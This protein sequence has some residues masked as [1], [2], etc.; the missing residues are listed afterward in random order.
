MVLTLLTLIAAVLDTI[1]ATVVW[2]RFRGMRAAWYFVATILVRTVFAFS[3]HVYLPA[4]TSTAEVA[5]VACLRWVLLPLASLFQLLFFLSAYEERWLTRPRVRAIAAAFALFGALLTADVAARVAP[6]FEAPGP[7]AGIDPFALGPRP[8]LLVLFQLGWL[9]GIAVLA[10]AMIRTP[11]ER[12]PLLFVLVASLAGV[13]LGAIAG[14]VGE[15]GDAAVLFDV[16][17]TG[18]FAYLLFRRHVFETT[19]IAIDGALASMAEGIAVLADDGAVLFANPS[20][21]ALLRLRA[22]MT[23][24]I[25]AMRDPPVGEML[26]ALGAQRDLFQVEREEH[27]VLLTASPI[28]DQDGHLRGHLLLAQ[29]VTEQEQAR[30]ARDRAE[31]ASAAK[32]AFLSHM[33]HELRTPLNAILGFSQLLARD[34]TLGREPR[35]HLAVI[36]RSG[37]HLLELINGVLDLSKIEAGRLALVEAR[38]AP[39]RLIADIE[40][41][42]RDMAAEKGLAFSVHGPA[43]PSALLGDERKLRQILINLVG[44]ALKFTERGSVVVR[45]SAPDFAESLAAGEPCR[46]CF[47]IEDTGP[48]IEEAARAKLFR[49]FSSGS[50]GP[51]SGTGLGLVISREL[52]RALGGEIHVAST[53]GRGSTFSFDVRLAIAPDAEPA[54]VRDKRSVMSIVPGQ[55]PIRIL[56]A[57]DREE[58][59]D[60]L[61]EL[62][63]GV[64]FEVRSVPNGRDAIEQWEAWQPHLIWMDMRMPVLDGY[65]ATRRIKATPRGQSTVIIAL[66]ASAFEQDRQEVLAAGCDDFVRKPLRDTEVFEKIAS[67]L[68]VRYVYDEGEDRPSEPYPPDGDGLSPEVLLALPAPVRERLRHSAESLNPRGCRAAIAEIPAEHADAAAR[69]GDLVRAYR[70]DRILSLFD[71]GGT[72]A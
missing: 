5:A 45:A 60:L 58:N 34:R 68:G 8:A 36:E 72:H 59:R 56:I 12:G 42:F 1:L 3:H 27:N 40:V 49:A 43:L 10:R 35:R 52:V 2:L 21:E 46:L 69:L 25:I 9:P 24:E 64:G 61:V 28:L 17:V 31:A 6:L 62:L 33:S 18:S 22:G 44:N 20:M 4:A 38:F 55:E 19:K 13:A 57:D 39:A 7:V 26:R 70:F 29:D 48:G 30:R 67:H 14:Q 51:T 71:N 23:A 32:S 41:M 37:R 53:P 16:I 54:E 63:T 47:E 50:S 65:E 15:L 11:S 66:T